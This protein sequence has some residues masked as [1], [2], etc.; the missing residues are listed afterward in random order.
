MGFG[1]RKLIDI[2]FKFRKVTGNFLCHNN[3]LTSLKGSPLEVGGSFWCQNNQLNSLEY[4][5]FEVGGDFT[6]HNNRLTDL[7]GC[8]SEV[9]GNFVC[10]YNKLVDLDISTIIGK[11]L[12]CYGNKIDPE[13]YTFYG[14]VGG[15]IVFKDYSSGIARA[16]RGRRI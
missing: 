8:P 1:V 15:K 6:C 2:P 16:I 10:S 5:P 11:D 3:N 12:I 7:D 13:N 14:E 9:G 4:C